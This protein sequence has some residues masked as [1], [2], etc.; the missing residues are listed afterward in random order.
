MKHLFILFFFYFRMF[1]AD[2]RC[3]LCD[4]L[5]DSFWCCM[6]SSCHDRA[7]TTYWCLA[8]TETFWS[9]NRIT[10]NTQTTSV[11]N[12]SPPKAAHCVY[13]KGKAFGDVCLWSAVCD[14]LL[15]RCVHYDNLSATQPEDIWRETKPT[16]P[17][18][19][20]IPKF[21]SSSIVFECYSEQLIGGH[22]QT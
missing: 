11:R 2:Y 1:Q 20:F 19:K 12:S 22:C 7:L 6:N 18:N 21:P 15:L 10:Q 9:I 4:T 13:R 14:V 5:F 3:F 8:C 16:I 17:T